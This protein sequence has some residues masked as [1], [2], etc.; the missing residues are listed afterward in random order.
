M[1][2]APDLYFYLRKSVHIISGILFLCLANQEGSVY[3]LGIFVLLVII[4]DLSRH[5]IKPWKNFFHKIFRNY[6]KDAEVKASPAGA[7]TLWTGLY[8]TLV[9]FPFSTFVAAGSVAVFADPLAAISGRLAGFV[10]LRRG[11]T[12]A[13]SVIFIFISILLLRWYWNI[14]LIHSIF[15]SILLSVVEIFS[16]PAVE[17]FLL[18][19][20]GAT[21]VELFTV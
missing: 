11:K 12:T 14:P 18:C 15:I 16:P 19:M 10:E 6:L 7:T 8:A 17:N 3:F 9:I 4:L 21:L 20:A 5:Y 1:G 13:G 2:K